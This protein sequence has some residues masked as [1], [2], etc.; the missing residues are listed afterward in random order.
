MTEKLLAEKWVAGLPPPHC[1][2]LKEPLIDSSGEGRISVSFDA[3]D[4]LSMATKNAVDSKS[5]AFRLQFS[6]KAL[7]LITAVIGVVFGGW[8]EWRRAAI[9]RRCRQYRAELERFRYRRDPKRGIIMYAGPP[10]STVLSDQ[11]L[12]DSPQGQQML[13]ATLRNERIDPALRVNL[14]MSLANRRL[15]GL[16][17]LMMDLYDPAAG[18]DENSWALDG[19]GNYPTADVAQHLIHVLRTNADPYL[20][21]NAAY[22]LALVRPVIRLPDL[23]EL[24]A[25]ETEIEPKIGLAYALRRCG[26]SSCD[27]WLRQV[28]NAEKGDVQLL[29]LKALSP[30]DTEP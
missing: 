17:K 9:A 8:L 29:A 11:E 14:G 30:N 12:L 25:A 20:R 13:L 24:F 16:E 6:L 10:L 23:R 3:K 15:P 5:S 19:L 2:N 27:A 26:D 1:C 4:S 28:A 21:R 7:L 22:S 18:Y